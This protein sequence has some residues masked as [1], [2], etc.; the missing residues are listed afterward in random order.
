MEENHQ[1]TSTA[2]G[3]GGK[4][5][6][7]VMKKSSAVSSTI[8]FLWLL[9][10]CG[11]VIIHQTSQPDLQPI[12]YNDVKMRAQKVFFEGHNPSVRFRGTGK[13]IKFTEDG[14]R[15]GTDPQVFCEYEVTGNPYVKDWGPAALDSQFGVHLDG[16]DVQT[17]FKQKESA[18]L[19]AQL[20]YTL[21]QQAVENKVARN[22]PAG[23][24][25]PI[26]TKTIKTD[27]DE[28][29]AIHSEPQQNAYAVVIGIEHYRSIPKSDYSRNDAHLVKGY[30]KT[31]GFQERNI[32]LITDEKATK[33]DIEKSLEAWLPNR[34]RKDSRVFVYFSGHGAPE[35]ATGEAYLVPYDGDPNYLPVTG[36]RLKRL[37]DSLGKLEAKE[38][39]VVLDSCFSG[40]G[41]RSV[42]AKGARPLVMMAPTGALPSNMAVLSATQGSQI[43]TS[44]PEKGHG[45]LTYYFL[46][47]IKDGKKDLA[48][49]YEHIL[50]Q[51]EDDAKQLNVQQSPSI[52]PDTEKI[53]GRFYLVK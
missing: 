47:A 10:G 6:R 29:P 45:V 12:P 22:L 20:L 25:S 28:L 19:F 38:I 46:K 53:K 41:G 24:A 42:L 21:K 27:I 2:G 26:E 51:V 1:R 14:F 3:R 5:L 15:I 36:Y 17:W 39:I 34:V 7:R 50:P 18:I 23:T 35:P 37:Y 13:A 43:S 44:S 4:K 31:L 16:C 11:G 9:I 52:R 32:D 49:I 40:G 30:L 48:E 33:T 8:V